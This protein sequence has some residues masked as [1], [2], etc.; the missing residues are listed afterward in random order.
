MAHTR[1]VLG[2]PVSGRFCVV[3]IFE[4]QP[5]SSAFDWDEG[6]LLEYVP[7]ADDWEYADLDGFFWHFNKE[8]A[9]PRFFIISPTE[10]IGELQCQLNAENYSDQTCTTGESPLT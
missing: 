3:W 6:R 5:W 1:E 8:S 4:G 7:D 2:M 9:R 10:S